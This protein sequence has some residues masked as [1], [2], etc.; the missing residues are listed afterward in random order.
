MRSKDGPAIFLVS[1]FE[2]IPSILLFLFFVKITM[3]SV[4]QLVLQWLISR[5]FLQYCILI[6][7]LAVLLLLLWLLMVTVTVFIECHSEYESELESQ[8]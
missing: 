1:T 5:K 2:Q 8:I 6:E 3:P 4:L 7:I